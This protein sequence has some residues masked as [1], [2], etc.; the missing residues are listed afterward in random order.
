LCN[1][2]VDFRKNLFADAL[3]AFLDFVHVRRPADKSQM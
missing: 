2:W 1:R 3:P